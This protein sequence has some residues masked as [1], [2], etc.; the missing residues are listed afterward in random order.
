MEMINDEYILNKG[1]HSVGLAD[2]H[3]KREAF[4]GDY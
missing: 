4:E 1:V 2:K 3:D